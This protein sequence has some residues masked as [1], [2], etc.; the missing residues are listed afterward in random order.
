MNFIVDY[1]ADLL[2][3]CITNDDDDDNFEKG[4]RA[5]DD[6]EKNDGRER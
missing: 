4:D 1:I 2:Y 5:D 3:F 6:N